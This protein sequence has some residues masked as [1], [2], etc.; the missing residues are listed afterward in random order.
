MLKERE[1]SKDKVFI[2]RDIVEIR[3]PK[4]VYSK[5]EK[6]YSKEYIVSFADEKR[7]LKDRKSVV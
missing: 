2:L 5:L 1:D 6:R 4:D 7:V 3:I